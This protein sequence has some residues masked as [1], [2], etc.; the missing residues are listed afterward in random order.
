MKVEFEIRGAVDEPY[1]KVHGETVLGMTLRRGSMDIGLRRCVVKTIRFEA[2]MMGL[3]PAQFEQWI[4]SSDMAHVT[5][6]ISDVALMAAADGHKVELRQNSELVDSRLRALATAV[7]IERAAGFPNGPIFL[8]SIEQALATALVKGYAVDDYAV[9]PYRGGLGPGR[10]RKIRE[11]VKG[12]ID[13]DLS[14]DEMARAVGLSAG[15]F[16]EV[17]RNTTGETPHQ[18]ILRSR[19][20]RAKEMLCSS[21]K[22]RVLDVA[23]ACGFKNQQHFARVFRQLCGASP[24]EYRYRICG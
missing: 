21:G 20:E 24:T 11:L 2:G 15:H 9:Q 19:I 5:M 16:S 4:G 12:K 1:L 3:C 8:D 6:T 10:L 17:F 14:L 7:D 22:S 18:Y 23:I 13:E